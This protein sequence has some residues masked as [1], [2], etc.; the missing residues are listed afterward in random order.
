[1]CNCFFLLMVNLN[2]RSYKIARFLI[3]DASPTSEQTK[4]GKFPVGNPFVTGLVIRYRRFVGVRSGFCL[5]LWTVYSRHSVSALCL[6]TVGVVLKPC[7][8][9]VSCRCIAAL[10]SSPGRNLITDG[11]PVMESSELRSQVAAVL[12]DRRS[13]NY[14]R[15]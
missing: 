6:P 3:I 12:Y 10:P 13:S 4:M 7:R 9:L 5:L 14:C 15:P 8:T 2:V 1:V 11:L